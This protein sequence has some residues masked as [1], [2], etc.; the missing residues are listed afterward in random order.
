ME[1]KIIRIVNKSPNPD[2]VYA[3]EGDSGFDLRAWTDEPIILKPLERKLVHTGIYCELP[4]DTEIQVRPRSGCALKMGLSVC[5]TPG[6][7]DL[8]Y[9]GEIGVIAINLSNENLTINNGDRI[10]QAVLC[11]VFN[12]L[13]VEFEKI[14]EVSSNEKRGNA[15]FGTTGIK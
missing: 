4:E 2:P 7:I 9:S 1:K 6:T 5:N 3:K 13:N 15:G 14:S 11:P 8:F 12:S 10:A